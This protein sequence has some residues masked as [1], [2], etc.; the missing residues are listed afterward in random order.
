MGFCRGKLLAELQ[1]QSAREQKVA[2]PPY[3]EEQ[4]S[5]STKSKDLLWGELGAPY[6]KQFFSLAFFTSFSCDWIIILLN[7]MSGQSKSDY[8]IE[9]WRRRKQ[10]TKQEK[11]KCKVHDRL[12]PFFRFSTS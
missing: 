10:E 3:L 7:L 4:D 11:K 1:K 5:E 2:R 12:V 6:T 8:A 9:I